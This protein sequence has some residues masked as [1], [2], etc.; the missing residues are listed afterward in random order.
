MQSEEPRVVGQGVVVS[1]DSTPLSLWP[2]THATGWVSMAGRGARANRYCTPDCQRSHWAA[3]KA[4]CR[5][6]AQEDHVVLDVQDAAL[7]TP[8]PGLCLC[9]WGCMCGW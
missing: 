6:H 8:L 1:T 9:G 3:H 4:P 5:R 2:T 7:F